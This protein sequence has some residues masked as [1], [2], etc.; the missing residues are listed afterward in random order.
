M[1]GQPVSTAAGRP[2]PSERRATWLA[3]A[4]LLLA[5]L[6]A[7]HNS[8]SAPFL[9]DDDPSITDNPTIRTFW[10]PWGALSPPMGGEGVTSRPVV[11]YSFAVNY[12]L[13]GLDVRGYH[14]VNLAIHL[15]AALLLFGIVRRT[16]RQPVLR[17]HFGDHAGL[18]AFAIAFAW[19]LHP[20]QTE[21]VTCVVQRTESLM[22]LFYLLTL[23]AAI[24]AI[25]APRPGQWQLF[26]F[27]A[28]LAGMESKEVMVSAPLI[29]LLYDRTF[30]AGSFRAAWSRRKWSYLSLAATWGVLAWLVLGMGQ[31]NRGGTCGFATVISWWS[32]LFTQAEGIVR[33]LMLS[34]WPRPLV[35]DYGTY[36]ARDPVVIASCFALLA[37]LGAATIVALWRRPVWGFVGAWFFAILAPSSS[38]VP[39]ATQTLAEHRMYLPLAAVLALTVA[40]LQ[41]LAGPRGLYAAIALAAALGGMTVQRN[42]DYRSVVSIWT[43]TVAKRPESARAQAGLGGALLM[44][45]RADEAIPYCKRALQL[46][47][48]SS[49]YL[50]GSALIKAGRPADAIPFYQQAL[51]LNPKL[52]DFCLGYALLQA[53]RAAEAIPIYE[54]TLR[55]NPDRADVCN[56]LG[57]ALAEV[58]R[59]PEAIGC[60]ERALRL[61]PGFPEAHNDLGAVL[62]SS[63]RMEE[64]ILHYRQALQGRPDYVEAEY[65][66][67]LALFDTGQLDEALAA[68]RVVVQRSPGLVPAWCSLGRA[69]ARSGRTAEAASSFEEALRRAPDSAEARDGLARLRSGSR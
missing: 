12:A 21:S 44:A 64:A 23:Y 18:M 8:L 25:E 66:L 32:Y 68:F 57:N 16:L 1:G 2:A 19:L 11:N 22:G 15:G 39:L 58:G 10:P 4:A 55:L 56:D 6:V 59:V 69:L 26:A 61:W 53:G 67:G 24:R 62:Y 13:G 46:D 9:F 27:A 14:A 29:V 3:V 52:T 34:L 63:G 50:L 33:Y 30:V 5:G 42:T 37:A 35:M 7:Y 43:D 28:C 41:R 49:S 40:G 51:R 48:K 17:S 38:V 47:P 20:L 31:G 60:Y 45:N 36:V 65:N 54:R